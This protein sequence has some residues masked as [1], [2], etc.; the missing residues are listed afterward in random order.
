[1]DIICPAC[2]THNDPTNLI[3]VVCGSPLQP[4]PVNQASY[5][6]Y[7]PIG[8]QLKNGEFEIQSILG[9]GGFG[10]TYKARQRDINKL[11]AIKELLPERSAR[12]GTEIIWSHLITPNEKRKF[13]D[14]INNEFKRTTLFSHPNIVNAIELFEENN[15]IYLVLDF[16]EGKTLAQV[17]KENNCIPESKARMYLKSLCEALA[18]IHDN[19]ILH[20]DIKPENIIID[21]SDKPVLIDLGSAREF[22][23][24]QTKRYT[25]LLTEDYAPYEQRLEYTK[26]GPYT[27]IY[28]L[29]VTFYQALTGVLPPNSVSRVQDDTIRTPR[30]IKPELSSLIERVLLDG[31]HVNLQQRFQSASEILDELDNKPRLLR[32][33]REVARK[34]NIPD[35]INLYQKIIS[36][37]P[38]STTALLEMA[39]LQLGTSPADAICTVKTI[40]KYEPNS[41]EAYGISGVAYCQLKQ[42][43]KAIENLINGIKHSPSLIWIRLNLAYALSEI[44]EC[45]RAELILDQILQ[46][47]VMTQEILV[48]RTWI[49]FKKSNWPCVIRFARQA[50]NN[51]D[52]EYNYISNVKKN[53]FPIL[54]FA[55]E[56]ATSYR[57]SDMF[58][59]I[60]ELQKS[61]FDEQLTFDLALWH[62]LDSKNYSAVLKLIDDSRS[63]KKDSNLFNLILAQAHTGNIDEA[64][65]TINRVDCSGHLSISEYILL[66]NLYSFEKLWGE[67][68]EAFKSAISSGCN[69]PEVFHALGWVVLNL[70]RQKDSNED[71]SLML[72]AYRQAYLNYSAR[73]DTTKALKIANQFAKLGV[74][75]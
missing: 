2:T 16:I 30:S 72:S 50:L 43:N 22:T 58:M 57:S 40:L 62:C 59:L 67:S 23:L 8:S 74:T 3:C 49:S 31:L 20:L 7:L 46:H 73:G 63:V 24:D 45:T 15:T 29:C 11:F 18:F 33:A 65:K 19:Q 41:G 51:L 10:V 17:I 64:I 34:G 55:I 14:E 68:K 70:R 12:N 36:E 61:Y 71:A 53:I 6:I 56:K 4:S 39:Y 52:K 9:E 75:M 5:S 42:W 26:L 13:I 60:K 38:E 48:L 28:A 35:S 44:N 21:K 27:D 69:D 32:K 1:M 25:R 66:G 54:A 37:N 47:S